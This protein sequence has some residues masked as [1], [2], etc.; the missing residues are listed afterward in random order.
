MENSVLERINKVI[1]NNGCSITFLSKELG[2]VQTTL[3]RQIKGDVQ[4]SAHTIEAF[5]HYFP[6]LS[7]EWLLRGK[8]EMLL[9]DSS[10]LPV[11]L[12][13]EEII[14][15]RAEN[16]VLREMVGLKRRNDRQSETEI[17]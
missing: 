1:Y 6:N 2:I 13:D 3:N 11:E 5:L 8:G 14:S 9:G 12:L 10:P 15:L 17:A 4:L 7:A 16:A